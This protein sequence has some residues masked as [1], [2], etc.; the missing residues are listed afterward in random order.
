MA[1]AMLSF[2]VDAEL[3][4]AF[5][6]VAAEQGRTD[7]DLLRL[8]MRDAVSL[9][10]SS[11]DHDA[12]VRGEVAR[13]LDNADDPLSV[14]RSPQDEVEARWRQQR[15]H[16]GRRA[17]GAPTRGVPERDVSRFERIVIDP[18]VMAGTPCVRGTRIPVA[19]VV[20]LMA[21]SHSTEE[22]QRDFP[23]LSADDISESLRYAAAAINERTLP[24]KARP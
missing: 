20:G 4:R 23:Q 15:E 18:S 24:A 1:D 14:E 2:A 10:Q 21:D 5:A 8:L 9:R 6:E 13:A 16:H 3:A 12:W 7:E 17:N 22:V 11:G 19:T